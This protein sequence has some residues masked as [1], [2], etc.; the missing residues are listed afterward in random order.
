M[1]FTGEKVEGKDISV[2]NDKRFRE[3]SAEETETVKELKQKFHDAKKRFIKNFH[4]LLVTARG[5]IEAL[6]REQERL[7]MKLE[8]YHTRKCNCKYE[9]ST[10]NIRLEPKYIKVMRGRATVE[11][12]FNDLALMEEWLISNHL[13]TNSDGLPA[14][15]MHEEP[16][17]TTTNSLLICRTVCGVSLTFCLKETDWLL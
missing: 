14:T 13:D 4:S 5:E 7:Q 10:N 9:V 3:Q 16:T 8:A 17:L 11:L 6:K 12:T 2:K 15:L 1:D